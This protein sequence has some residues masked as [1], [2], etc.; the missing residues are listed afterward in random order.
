MGFVLDTSALTINLRLKLELTQRSLPEVVNKAARDVTLRTVQFSPVA[1]PASI[2]AQLSAIIGQRTHSKTGRVLKRPRNIT[3]PT[4]LARAIFIS[5]LW[6]KGIN[7]HTLSG[8]EIDAGIRKMIT[9]RT[10]SVGYLKSG[11]LTAAELFGGGLPGVRDFGSHRGTAKLATIDDLFAL[12]KNDVPA[13][14]HW[15]DGSSAYA[16]AQAAL[17]AGVDYVAADIVPYIDK[18]LREAGFG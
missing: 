5:R 3:K 10:R 11:Y 7:P 12:I 1:D 17:Q 14:E 8:A 16:Q 15:R 18:K 2:A 13:D 6:K 9:S 4:D